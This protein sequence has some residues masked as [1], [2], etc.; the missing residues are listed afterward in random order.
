MFTQVVR[1]TVKKGKFDR[2]IQKRRQFSA[3]VTGLGEIAAKQRGIQYFKIVGPKS[4][5][6][7]PSLPLAVP[8]VL[9]NSL[10]DSRQ[11]VEKLAGDSIILTNL[12]QYLF[13]SEWI[14]R[15]ESQTSILLAN[16]PEKEGQHIYSLL[17]RPYVLSTEGWL[18]LQGLSDS[19]IMLLLAS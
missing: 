14:K 11:G 19:Q 5:S 10:A 6:S 3:V 16:A 8:G 15:K 12:L 4:Q 7:E 1:N 18:K 17:T 2:I 9:A 13:S